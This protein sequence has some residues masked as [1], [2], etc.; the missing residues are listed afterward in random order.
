M[1]PHTYGYLIFDKEAK[2]IQWKKD[3]TFNEWCWINYRSACRRMQIDPFLSHC[4]KLKSKWIKD[5]HIKPGTLTL[6]EEKL[7]E[8]PI[9]GYRGKLP[10]QNTN[11]LW[12]KINN[13]QMRP[14]KIAKL[15]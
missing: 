8:S 6:I 9:L 7:G 13:R 10:E 5:L 4:T 1:N 14:Q 12:S 3:R 15:L 11:G 2:T